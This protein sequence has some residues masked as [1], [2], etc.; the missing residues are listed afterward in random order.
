[1]SITN[2]ETSFRDNLNPFVPKSSS[3]LAN[4]GYHFFA[5]LIK[6]L[7]IPQNTRQLHAF[8]DTGGILH[9]LD[10]QCFSIGGSL[11]E[12]HLKGFNLNLS[13]HI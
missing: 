4:K 10:S 2:K 9:R 1:M 5:K 11:Y 12:M 8:F 6:N 13:K 7:P 3:K